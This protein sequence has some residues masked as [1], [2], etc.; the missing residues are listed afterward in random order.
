MMPVTWNYEPNV[1]FTLLVTIVTVFYHSN[2]KQNY[3]IL[4]QRTEKG[5]SIEDTLTVKSHT[6]LELREASEVEEPHS[7]YFILS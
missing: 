3:D 4:T 7:S 1:P 2:S 6:W 5:K